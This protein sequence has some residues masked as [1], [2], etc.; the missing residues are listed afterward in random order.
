MYNRKAYCLFCS[1]LHVIQN[2]GWFGYVRRTHA[3][4]YQ[5]LHYTSSV[6]I[7]SVS[8]IRLDPQVSSQEGKQQFRRPLPKREHS[9]KG[10]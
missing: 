7:N 9:L 2:K 4:T 10:R 5:S 3:R 6:V 8:A 1:E